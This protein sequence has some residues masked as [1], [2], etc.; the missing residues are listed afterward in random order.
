MSPQKGSRLVDGVLP[1]FE[2][3]REDVPGMDHVVE[4]HQLMGCA[5]VLES[6]G[7]AA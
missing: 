3:R 1:F 7:Q 4:D 5:R 2:Q 6:L